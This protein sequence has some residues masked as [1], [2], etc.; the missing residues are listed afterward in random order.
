MKV[1]EVGK[2]LNCDFYNEEHTNNCNKFSNITGCEMIENEDSIDQRNIKIMLDVLKGDT[3]RS[4]SKKYN[5][6]FNH[7]TNVGKETIKK[8]TN[9]TYKDIRNIQH[10]QKIIKKLE[11]KLS[12]L[13]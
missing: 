12:E 9:I 4:V 11:L 3:F 5:I 13:S 8:F 2:K 6:S 10:N 1:C 7:L